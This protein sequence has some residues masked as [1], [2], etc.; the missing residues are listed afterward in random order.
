MTNQNNINLVKE[1]SSKLINCENDFYYMKQAVDN[2]YEIFKTITDIDINDLNTGEII[3]P[4]GKAI[5]PSSAAHC[6][7]EMKRTAIFLRGI[8]KAIDN[9][10]NNN[11][12]TI[13]ILYAGC[14]P[15]AT[16][17]TPLLT[18]YKTNDLR[19]TLLDINQ[20][21][22]NS[23]EKLVNELRF[24]DF[25]DGYILADASGYKID[26]DYDIV[27]S[28]T[29]QACLKNEPQVSIMQN[30]I[31]Q[32]KENAIFIPQQITIDAYLKNPG[33]WDEEK[34]QRIGIE[35]KFLKKIFSIDCNNLDSDKYRATVD[36]PDNLDGFIELMLHT[37]IVVFED[38]IL[39]VNNCSLNMPI[40][41]YE[42]KEQYT[43]A[44][45]FWYSFLPQPNI[46]TR[47][48]DFA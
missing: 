14:G 25:I 11:T 8:K 47:V 37:T 30:L 19:I 34:A 10:G 24:E 20:T 2:L 5:S 31:P 23:A 21:S 35:S 17:I 28:E 9:K 33:R 45:E 12:G 7:L 44:I 46:E 43:K 42:F 29:M 36:I 15:Y 26:K 27:I 48:V 1:A 41:F 22:L 40:K 39:E 4:S 18:M 16:L 6:L 32:M 38:E 13:N 3:L